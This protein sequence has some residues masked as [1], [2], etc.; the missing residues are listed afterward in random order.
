[1][2]PRQQL[3]RLLKLLQNDSVLLVM[4]GFERELRAYGGMGAAYQGDEVD[5]EGR[6]DDRDCINPNAETF[7][8]SL[9][10][11]PQMRGKV[12]MTTRLRPGA[13]EMRGSMTRQ[14][15]CFTIA[16]AHQSTSNSEPTTLK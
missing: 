6:Q 4:D 12:L 11:L 5:A 10:S 9:C 8:R 7:L 14:W 13:V 2:P 15:T 16:S 3:D 1:M